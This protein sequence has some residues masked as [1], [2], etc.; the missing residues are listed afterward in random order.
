MTDEYNRMIDKYNLM[1]A[2]EILGDTFYIDSDG[3]I[4]IQRTK[5]EITEATLTFLNLLLNWNEK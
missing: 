2:Q 5:K 4:V 3:D 1:D